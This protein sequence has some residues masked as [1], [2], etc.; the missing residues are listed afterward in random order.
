MTIEMKLP[1]A[2]RRILY[3]LVPS[4]PLT[5]PR[6]LSLY[7]LASPPLMGQGCCECA[8]ASVGEW[9]GWVVDWPVGG[10]VGLLLIGWYGPNVSVGP[11]GGRECESRARERDER[12]KGSE[13]DDVRCAEAMTV[14]LAC[15][16]GCG[17]C[18]PPAA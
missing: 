1:A 14:A 17:V 5:F 3:S 15:L 11:S 12:A 6:V 4:P 8:R 10:C 16:V 18:A 9:F 13:V 7:R 2:E